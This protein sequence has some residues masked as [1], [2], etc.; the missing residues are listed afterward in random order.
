MPKWSANGWIRAATFLSV[1][2]VSII[3]AI[4]SYSHIYR[5]ALTH[6]QSN[7]DSKLLPLSVD[8]LILAATLT[9]F[10]ASRN[11]L[12][13][14]KLARCMLALGIGATVGINM[15]Y[16]W[17]DGLLGAALSAWPAVSFIGSVELTI[18]TFR[19]AVVSRP[20][21]IPEEN[22]GLKLTYKAVAESGRRKAV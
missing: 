5:V 17:S 20:S 16:G 15:L 8:G 4:V 13:V 14:P 1:C 7:L 6:G 2:G 12:S 3:A 9:A 21:K 19:L 18:S 11:R 22:D 10:I